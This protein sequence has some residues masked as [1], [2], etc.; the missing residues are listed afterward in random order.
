MFKFVVDI[1]SGFL[2]ILA[3]L[4]LTL[5]IPGYQQYKKLAGMSVSRRGRDPAAGTRDR[6]LCLDAAAVQAYHAIIE[7]C[8]NSFLIRPSGLGQ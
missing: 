4:A 3:W 1:V 5:A 2:G 7:G 8:G 6:N